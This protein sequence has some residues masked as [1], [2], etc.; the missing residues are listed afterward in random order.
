[1]GIPYNQRFWT[2]WCF[3]LGGVGA[4]VIGI[5]MVTLRVIALQR[6]SSVPETVVTSVMEGP[7]SD[8]EGSFTAHVML[9]CAGS[10]RR[11]N[12]PTNSVSGEV[13]E[14]KSLQTLSLDIHKVQPRRS[15]VILR[16]QRGLILRLVIG[17][18]FFSACINDC[19]GTAM[20]GIFLRR[21][22]FLRQ[23]A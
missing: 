10:S 1:M 13:A 18:H 12:F 15:F 22:L 19:N 21:W 6:W 8:S 14:K 7:D 16:S 3:L 5:V 9:R 20:L 4:L 2:V 23:A 11:E 17:S